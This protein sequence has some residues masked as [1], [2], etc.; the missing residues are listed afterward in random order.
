M[1]AK[2]SLRQ[3]YIDHIMNNNYGDDD[4]KNDSSNIAFLE[5]LSLNELANMIDNE[6][7]GEIHE[8]TYEELTGLED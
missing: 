2:Q 6:L 5:S 7:D 1:T 4:P 3:K 8:Q